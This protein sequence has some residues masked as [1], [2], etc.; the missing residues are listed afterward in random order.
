[1][2][3]FIRTPRRPPQAAAWT[4]SLVRDGRASTTCCAAM[5]G[6]CLGALTGLSACTVV[7][8]PGVVDEPVVVQAPVAVEP[9]PVVSVYVDPPFV[10]PAPVLVPWAPPPLL[11]QAP[12]PP[13]FIDMVWVGGYWAW[14][15]CW[16]WSAGYWDRPPRQGYVWMEPYYEHRGNAVVFVNR[17]WAAPGVAFVPPPARLRLSLSMTLGGAVGVAPRGPQ[18]VF[19]PAPPGSTA[20]LIVPAPLGTPPAVVTGA[21]AVVRPGMRIVNSNNVTINNTVNNTVVNNITLLNERN[22]RNVRVEAPASATAGHL[23]FNSEVPARAALA[24]ATRPRTPWTAPLPQSDRRF[25]LA[26]AARH[27]PFVLPPAQ[28]IRT[29]RAGVPVQAP[30]RPEAPMHEAVERPAGYAGSEP[31]ATRRRA[32]EATSERAPQVPGSRAQERNAGEASR[33]PQG[34]TVRE[35][36][37]PSAPEPSRAWSG[38]PERPARDAARHA[39]EEGHFPRTVEQ[40]KEPME[41]ARRQP[42]EQRA[43]RPAAAA[44]EADRARAEPRP[45]PRPQPR[46]PERRQR[47]HE[48]ED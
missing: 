26:A 17:F 8:P 43:A 12:P 27:P 14:Q 42:V 37:A 34:E 38:T 19:V 41:H 44:E 5:M 36:M 33:T 7:E 15:N 6:L 40:R 18:G 39:T 47:E 29:S 1:M 45:E 31:E 35:Y 23:A 48:E 20:G 22:I 13:P 9:P 3:S 16:V 4:G 25:E 24:A 32:Q 2:P 46:P 21:P 11:V 30:A 28:P 10:Q